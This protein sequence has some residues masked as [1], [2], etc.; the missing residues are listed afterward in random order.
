MT[1]TPIFLVSA[2]LLGLNTRYDGRGKVNERCCSMTKGAHI[3]PI[4][5]EQLGG[6]PTPRIAADIVGGDGGDVL[7]GK[8]KVITRDG[9]DVTGNFIQGA[10]QVLKIARLQNVS[11]ICLKSRSPSCGVELLGVTGAL[12]KQHG[13]VL[14]EF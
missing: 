2:C 4:C 9:R 13:F 14:Y 8:A 10:Q 5:P 1:S 7:S 3:V 11:G 12:L 6:L